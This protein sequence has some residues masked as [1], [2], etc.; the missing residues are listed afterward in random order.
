MDDETEAFD[1]TPESLEGTERYEISENAI[2][3]MENAMEAL[4]EASDSISNAISEL[5]DIFE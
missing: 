4:E 3:S 5:E 2:D 1:N